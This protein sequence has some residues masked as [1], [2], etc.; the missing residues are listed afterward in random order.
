MRSPR[1]RGHVQNVKVLAI[2]LAILAQLS[3][4]AGFFCAAIADEREETRLGISSLDVEEVIPVSHDDFLVTKLTHPTAMAITRLHAGREA[5]I[6]STPPLFPYDLGPSVITT[7]EGWW[8][9][10]HGDTGSGS[11]VYFVISNGER[12]VKRVNVPK[13]HRTVWLPVRGT[14]PHGVLVSVTEEPRTLQFHDVKPSGVRLLAAVPWFESGPER[15]L[16][17]GRWSAEHVGAGRFV[18]VTTEEAGDEGRVK[19]H[20]SPDLGEGTALP[21]SA[22]IDGAMDTAVDGAGRIAVVGVSNG[23]VVAMVA[24]IERPE[25]VRCRLVS[26]VGEIALA[27]PFGTPSV[28]WTGNAFVAAWIGSTGTIRACEFR[29]LT[30]PPLV[31][32]VGHDAH[33]D[34]P[35]RRLLYR[36]HEEVVF[37]W[38]TRSG[39]IAQRWMPGDV[40]GHT[41]LMDLMGRAC[42][43]GRETPARAVVFPVPV[44]TLR[45]SISPVA[46]VCQ[47][48]VPLRATF[49]A[50]AS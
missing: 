26:E 22:S 49:T 25:V 6:G 38:R 5:N 45:M 9:S 43:T 16:Q 10:R 33:L 39:E 17:Y 23:R 37:V 19:M 11:S 32:D 27:A 44:D 47:G 20:A 50:S 1:P 15:S 13:H 24:Q 18:I 46:I 48:G 21:C 42:T 8:F 12:Q 36:A 29:D 2:L 3:G 28:E 14:E 31:V 35:L 30:V 4:C 7:D 40:V 41:V 34:R